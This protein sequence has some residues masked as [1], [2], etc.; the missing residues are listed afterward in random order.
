MKNRLP[1]L[2]L[3]AA[4]ATPLEAAVTRENP[5]ALPDFRSQFMALDNRAELLGFH[6]NGFPGASG[7]LADTATHYQGIVRR[8]GRG[9]PIFFVA[10]AGMGD[11]DQGGILVVRMGSRSSDGERLRSNRLR[12]DQKSWDTEPPDLDRVVHQWKP[13]WKHVGGLALVGDVL[14]VP[15]EDPV[16]SQGGLEGAVWFYDVAEPTA[17]RRLRHLNVEY[18][19]HKAGV[20][21]LT[22]LPDRH[23]LLAVTWGEG[24]QVKFY[25]STH[26]S[27]LDTACRWERISTWES[28]DLVSEKADDK[29]PTGKTSFQGLALHT[30]QAEVYLV[31]TRNTSELTPFE[32][33]HDEAT[34]FRITGWEAG[35]TKVTVRQIASPRRFDCNAPYGDVGI[36]RDVYNANFLAGACTHVTPAG[37][38]L[39][40]AIEHYDWGA[41]G[42]VR[43]VEFRHADIARPDGPRY[44][45]QA[46]LPV[47]AFLPLGTHTV[48]LTNVALHGLRPW[49][50]LYDDDD[51]R[52]QR[53]TIDRADEN[54]EDYQDL[55][56]ID[57]S[58]DGFN[59]RT[60]ALRWWAPIG[61]QVKL[62]DS[63]NFGTDDATL[64]LPGTGAVGAIANLSDEPWKFD[65]GPQF[66][67]GETRLT[68]IRFL[69]PDEGETP[70]PLKQMIVTWSVIPA[71][72]GAGTITPLASGQARLTLTK[73]GRVLVV[74]R[75][76]GLTGGQHSVAAAVRAVNAPPEITQ[77]TAEQTA[78][79]LVAAQV[80]VRDPGNPGDVAVRIEWGDGEVT[81]GSVTAGGTFGA[82]HRFADANALTP[83]FEDFKLRAKVVDPEGLADDATFAGAELDGGAARTVRVTW[84][85][86]GPTGDGDG[87]GLP[88]IWEQERFGGTAAGGGDYDGDLATDF[89]EF[90]HG[91]NPVD[92]RD[93]PG[94]T[95]ERRHRE[96]EIR[97]PGRRLTDAV[98]GKT[99]R[100]YF[101]ERSTGLGT[102]GWTRIGEHTGQDEPVIVRQRLDGA[103]AGFYRLD[104]EL[105]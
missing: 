97:F 7:S 44:G 78:P 41:G 57:G 39:L 94:L 15:L 51:F 63:D 5:E 100:V 54:R 19:T 42:S 35:S 23:F 18:E 49:I 32:P 38:L 85:D 81:T 17:P 73:A 22:R 16:G 8:P 99:K 98:P 58:G 62:Y 52:G 27:L 55:G 86:P 56:K 47:P 29:W 25:R 93:A 20:A 46:E 53:L 12:K 11:G 43:L 40:Y 74:A 45:P 92:R 102:N 26:D 89:A 60:S 28:G 2:L 61:W 75:L 1:F 24:K 88:D 13:G 76:V 82:Q 79:G 70:D 90:M 68:S 31:G 65:N 96:L 37:E 36:T 72:D 14:A 34:P 30:S 67:S 21:G 105:R 101:L 91:T 83:V 87:D 48:A 104:A 50:Q 64:T 10:R 71:P 3:L 66:G 59:D 95:V 77:F 4:L 84:R 69:P 33:G 103:A 6:L 80:S 9:V